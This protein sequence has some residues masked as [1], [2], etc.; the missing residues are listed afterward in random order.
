ME[1]ADILEMTVSHLRALHRHPCHQYQQPTA[2]TD[3]A[4]RYLDGFKQCAVEVGRYFAQSGLAGS[5]SSV[6]MTATE[7]PMPVQPQPQL[8]IG[9]RLMRHLT[10]LLLQSPDAATA[11]PQS[12]VDDTVGPFRSVA[13]GDDKDSDSSFSLPSS[14]RRLSQFVADVVDRNE[15]FPVD[16]STSTSPSFDGQLSTC[17]IGLASVFGRAIE[18]KNEIGTEMSA[19]NDFRT[20]TV[21]TMDAVV[22]PTSTPSTV[23]NPTSVAQ[24]VGGYCHG[25]DAFSPKQADEVPIQ[26]QL[27][28]VASAD[29]RIPIPQAAFFISDKC[30]STA[31]DNKPLFH[32]GGDAAVICS[33]NLYCVRESGCRDFHCGDDVW[34]PW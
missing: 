1:K 18:I 16:L 4:D 13:Y 21:D 23:C 11:E 19:Y 15:R 7:S 27:T 22:P 29:T 20:V 33:S 25:S 10:S 9:A 5:G 14:D 34:R 32:I 30:V 17:C 26:R 12:A 8:M 24:I 2:S 28:S 3:V 31:S 6:S